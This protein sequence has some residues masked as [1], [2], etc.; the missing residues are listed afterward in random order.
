MA[1]RHG[2]SK[3]K[4]YRS[5]QHMK[6]RC[7]SKN[8]LDYHRYG[9]RGICVCKEWMSFINF[10]KDMGNSYKK[11]LTL[12]R[13]DNNGNYCKKNC[14][15]ATREEQANNKRSNRIIN[16]KN[17]RKTLEE[18]I[19]FFGLKS[20]TVRQRYYVYKFPLEKCFK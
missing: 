6:E 18:W 8:S 14:K 12:E 3:T 20:S 1:D 9:E 5:W 4:I 16:Y 10:Y 7:M 2:M 17:K 19:K 15:W 11:G 13:I